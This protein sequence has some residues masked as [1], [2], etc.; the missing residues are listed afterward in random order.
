MTGQE[1]IKEKRRTVHSISFKDD[2]LKI[3][4]LAAQQEGVSFAS[5]LKNAALTYIRESL[6]YQRLVESGELKET[7]KPIAEVIGDFK[8]TM[9]KSMMAINDNNS[10]RLKRIEWLIEKIIFILFIFNPPLECSPEKDEAIVKLALKRT[11]K[12]MDEYK[13]D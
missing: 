7:D 13:E 4:K 2:D 3:I 8:D 11:K 6:E 5:F 1:Q 9:G 10:R 12:I